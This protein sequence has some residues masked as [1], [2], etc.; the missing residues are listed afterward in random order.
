[1]LTFTDTNIKILKKVS[2]TFGDIEAKLEKLGGNPLV[3]IPEPEIRSF[4]ISNEHDF[5]VLASNSSFN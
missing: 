5:I 3:V 2:R 1:M 4:K